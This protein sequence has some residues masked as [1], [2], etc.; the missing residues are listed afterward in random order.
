MSPKEIVDSSRLLCALDEEARQQLAA[1]MSVRKAGK[2]D[3]IWVGGDAKGF[4]AVVG[5]G[6]IKMSR[7]GGHG[8]EVT[9]EIM[10]PGQV[11]G[12]NGI[13]FDRACPLNATAITDA[14][15]GYVSNVAIAPALQSNSAFKDA[16]LRRTMA[17]LHEKVDLLARMS[18]GRVDERIAAVLLTL[19]ESYGRRE[20]DRTVLE[21]PLT[22][23]QLAELAATT[24]E[25]A[26]R[27][28]TRWQAQRIVATDS[29]TI[30]ILD[31]EGLTAIFAAG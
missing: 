14:V 3:L 31:M 25:T 20:A 26:V 22:R 29:R 12:L 23:L 30:S 24:T 1:T 15:Y 4:F 19:A 5:S 10:G 27:V 16:L 17:R 9:I 7:P 18:S 11:F 28:M 6:Y 2:G 13:L 8:H 21:V